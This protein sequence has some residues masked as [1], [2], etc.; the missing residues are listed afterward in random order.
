MSFP[1]VILAGGL[2]TRLSHLTK[3]TPK[4]L[5]EIAGKPFIYHQLDLLKKQDIKEVIISVNYL[6]DQ[7]KKQ[8]GN[9]KKFGL[10]ISYAEDGDKQLGTGGAVKKISQTLKG[11]FFLLYGDSY[12][13]INFK[14]VLGSY[15]YEK[16][17][18]MVVY[19]NQNNYEKSNVLIKDSKILYSKKGSLKNPQHIDYGLSIFHSS[20][21]ETYNQDHFDLSLVQEDFSDRGELQYH[22]SKE[23]FYEIGSFEGINKL[24]KILHA[25]K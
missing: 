4:A 21:F 12:L 11:N 2:G 25:N 6:G 19:R 18:L 17:P 9:G 14:E 8:V 1:V 16:G 22:V 5:V 20:N 24:E 3:N 7:I 15:L 23:R 10:K 13:R